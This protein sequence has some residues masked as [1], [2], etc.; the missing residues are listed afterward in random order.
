MICLTLLD[1]QGLRG[2]CRSRFIRRAISARPSGCRGARKA[3]VVQHDGKMW[4]HRCERWWAYNN[5]CPFVDGDEEEEPFEDP[6]EH[7]KVFPGKKPVKK[8]RELIDPKIPVSVGTK[9]PVTVPELVEAVP[10]VAKEAARVAEAIAKPAVDP[11]RVPGGR[12][13]SDTSPSGAPQR[14][15]VNEGERARIRD[16]MRDAA[17]IA[18]RSSSSALN[19][20]LSRGQQMLASVHSL[21]QRPGSGPPNR[22][23]LLSTV[24]AAEMQ[25]SRAASRRRSSSRRRAGREAIEEAEA[26]VKGRPGPNVVPPRER[27]GLEAGKAVR[28]AVAA[29][30]A[31]GTG[32]LVRRSFGGGRGP[33]AGGG[34]NLRAPTFRPGSAIF[35]P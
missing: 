34:F 4:W 1:S 5:R 14:S 2:K 10:D 30:A 21:G 35:V 18:Q 33:P 32:Y 25:L 3:R 6:S 29:A 26:I 9:A 11:V 31:V 23:E 28:A 7:D 17:N 12:P 15:R 22:A 20:G 13:A 8:R 16:R 19:Q 24:R 27:E